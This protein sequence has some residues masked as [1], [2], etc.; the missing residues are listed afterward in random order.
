MVCVGMLMIPN[1]STTPYRNWFKKKGVKIVSIPYNTIKY[2]KYLNMID[3]L[4]IPGTVSGK[5]NSILKHKTFMEAATTYFI[6]SVQKHLPIWGTC[7]GFELLMCI[8]G[9]IT[10]CNMHSAH[11]L[12]PIHTYKS[13]LFGM[14]HEISNTFHNHDYGISVHDF[15]NNVHLRNFYNIS[16]T[17]ID[18]KNQEYVAAIESKHYPIY[19]VQWHPEKDVTSDACIRFFISEL[20]HS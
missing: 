7:F 14:V 5:G 4:F 11:G 18:D 15:K 16:A 10:K 19:G 13:R 20:T 17:A 1:T 12:Y 8:V 6:L 2:G 3:G 9:N